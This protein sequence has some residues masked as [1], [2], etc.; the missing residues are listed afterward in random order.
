MPT[1]FG[2]HDHRSYASTKQ[3]FPRTVHVR[4]FVPG[5]LSTSSDLVGKINNLAAPA[6]SAGLIPWI[7]FKLKPSD[8]A[9]GRWD[10]KLTAVGAK[11]DS[12]VR[13]IPYHEPE[14]DMSSSRF[15][16]MF[17]R[18]AARVKSADRG[19]RLV[20]SA[21]AYQFRSGSSTTANPAAWFPTG[22]DIYAADVYSGRSEPLTD[23]LPEHPGFKRWNRYRPKTKPWAIT[24]RGFIT[25]SQFRERAAQ[26]AREATWLKTSGCSVYIYWNT[27]GTEGDPSIVLDAQYGEPALRAMMASQ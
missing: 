16:S 19:H 6:L 7:S 22:A 5:E 25:R 1:I 20:Y 9:A 23:I 14:D 17:N 4:E 27:A 15:T 24:E 18:V 21:M 13:L 3:V 26:I 8:V 2:V 10:A 12:R 11:V